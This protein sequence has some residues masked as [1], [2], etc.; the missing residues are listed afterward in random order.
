M[1]KFASLR[2]D[3]L[4]LR[5]RHLEFP[6]QITKFIITGV[7]RVGSNLLMGLL[8]GHR[9]VTCFSELFHPNQIFYGREN[10]QRVDFG[11]IED[12]DYD[13]FAYLRKVYSENHG[14]GA[15]GFKILH[16]QNYRMLKFLV[17]RQ[18][19]RKIVLARRTLMHSYTSGLIAKE[20]GIYALRSSD[21][22]DV[23]PTRVVVDPDEF[24]AYVTK[25]RGFYDRVAR[26]LSD[27]EFYSVEF[28]NLVQNSTEIE[29]VQRFL[30]IENDPSVTPVHKK[31]SPRMLSDRVANWDEVVTR[32]GG[33]PYEEYLNQE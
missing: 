28:A 24:I 14:T 12:R 13:P 7:P 19:I 11:S 6:S 25:I 26:D 33:T 9:D 16:Q 30:G 29:N 20:T 5:N 4:Y 31:T 27:Q 32:L 18:D 21:R 2:L 15:V 17:K 1:R 8:N 23:K 22:E 10:R 3:W